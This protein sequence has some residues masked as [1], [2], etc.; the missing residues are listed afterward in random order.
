[1]NTGVGIG[2]VVYVESG[3]AVGDGIS[4]GDD[5]GIGTGVA[6][7]RQTLNLDQISWPH[8]NLDQIRSDFGPNVGPNLDQNLVQN[9]IFWSKFRFLDRRPGPGQNWTS[10]P[11]FGP[12]LVQIRVRSMAAPDLEHLKRLG[13][14]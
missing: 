1:M 12:N 5:D 13:F 4:T 10:G 6:P 9:L 7:P 3:T 14:L 2:T 8:P 11:G